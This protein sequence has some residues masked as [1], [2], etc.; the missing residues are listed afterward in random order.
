MDRKVSVDFQGQE[1][2]LASN[3]QYID[4]AS[5]VHRQLRSIRSF[6]NASDLGSNS[7]WSPLSPNE[8]RIANYLCGDR[9]EEINIKDIEDISIA[10]KSSDEYDDSDYEE[11]FLIDDEQQTGE[12]DPVPFTFESD[13]IPLFSVVR[14]GQQY[15]SS[16]LSRGELICLTLVWVFRRAQNH[17]IF[18]IDEPEAYLSPDSASKVLDYIAW[19]TD[20][21]KSQTVVATHAADAIIQLDNTLISL[22]VPSP[23]PPCLTRIKSA[24][25][26]TLLTDL[27][28]KG[29]STH[30]FVVEDVSAERIAKRL[31]SLCEFKHLDRTEFWR[32]GGDAGVRYASNLPDFQPGSLKVIS[33]ADGDEEARKDENPKYGNSVIFLPVKQNFEQF[34]LA[35]S[36][37]WAEQTGQYPISQVDRGLRLSL[38]K[39][40][41]DGIVTMPE[42]LGLTAA[43]LSSQIFNWWIR[44]PEGSQE[45][46]RFK[47][48]LLRLLPDSLA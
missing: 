31:L 34:I 48:D 20:K 6:A 24:E 17:S 18:F 29:K 21:K 41:H 47:R 11:E 37:N 2:I 3:I 22:L 12:E 13:Q 45:F 26:E 14:D 32:A 33:L 19:W 39:D 42:H 8:L 40:P 30:A 15:D 4:V 35:T 25:P 7:D 5:L 16:K 44:Q 36:H 46:S 28:L 43:D 23:T 38:G 27:R 1:S 9:Y 10:R